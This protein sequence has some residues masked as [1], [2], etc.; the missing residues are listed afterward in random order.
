MPRLLPALEVG[1]EVGI[2]GDVVAG[3]AVVGNA[4]ALVPHLGRPVVE[5]VVAVVVGIVVAA[6]HGRWTV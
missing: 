5:A 3:V 4:A 2:D 6:G 1:L